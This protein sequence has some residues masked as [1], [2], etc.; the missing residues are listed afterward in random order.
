MSQEFQELKTK[1]QELLRTHRLELE[2]RKRSKFL[3]DTDYYLQNR[4][5]AGVDKKED[6]AG[7]QCRPGLQKSDVNQITGKDLPLVINISSKN[8]DTHQI[9]LFQKGLSFCPMY[10]FNSF[11]LSMDLQRFYRSLRLQV[12][13]AD[14]PPVL[15]SSRQ[16]ISNLIELRGLGL[17]TSSSFMPPRYSPPVE[18]FVSLVERDINLFNRDVNRGKFHYQ[19]NLTQC[20]RLS[21]DQLSSDKTLII[22]PADEGGA[23]VIM[24]KTDYLEEVFRQLNDTSVY[25]MIPHNPLNRIA[26]KIKP[27]L[28]FH[29]QAG[30]IDSKMRDFLIKSDPVPPIFYILPKIHKR[31]FKPPGRPI[32][33]L[34]DSILSPLAIVLEN[35]PH[36]I[37]IRSL[38]PLL[39]TSFLITWDA[40]SLYT[41]LTHEKGLLATDRLLSEAGVDSK[42]QHFCA[43]L[44]DLVLK[45]NYFMFQDTFYIQQQGTAMVSNVAPPYAIAYMAAFEKDFVYPHPLFIDRCKIWQIYI[46]DIFCI[47][48]GPIESLLIFDNT[49]SPLSSSIYF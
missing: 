20:E 15:D 22:K 26:Q 45:E 21:L 19:T 39:T 33:S 18:T 34:T 1:N 37:V 10:K 38:G 48:D 8:L 3:R 27:V 28:D 7:G 24:D 4:G 12:H 6:E 31:Q 35:N 17:R 9:F 47:W 13:F 36:T 30:T 32:V 14:Q 41:S 5:T 46:D 25:K 23:T 16:G 42:I 29:L 11:K 40:N 2:K 49:L 44:L 43:D